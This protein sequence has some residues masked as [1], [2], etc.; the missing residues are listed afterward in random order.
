MQITPRWATDMYYNVST[1]LSIPQSHDQELMLPQCD[2]T[3]CTVQEWIITSSGQ[4]G[5]SEL[6][7]LERAQ[8]SRHREPHPH[9]YP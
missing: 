7:D 2:T 6:L 3:D 5:I 4:G 8:T 9:Q 1:L